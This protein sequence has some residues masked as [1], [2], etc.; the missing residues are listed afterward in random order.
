MTP[1][2]YLDLQKKT[3]EIVALAKD[4]DATQK[5]EAILQTIREEGFALGIQDEFR[6]IVK[7]IESMKDRKEDSHDPA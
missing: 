1:P 7:K 2:D 6:R 3:E 4:S 5:I